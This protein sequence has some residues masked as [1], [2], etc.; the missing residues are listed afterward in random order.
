M[1]RFLSLVFLLALPA[2]LPAAERPPNV[3]LIQADDKD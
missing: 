3:V 1:T 2:C